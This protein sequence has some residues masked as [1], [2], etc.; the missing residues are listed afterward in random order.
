M[1]DDRIF[2]S[3][4]KINVAAT[5]SLIALKAELLAK[6]NAAVS[7]GR[8]ET[9][10][11]SSSKPKWQIKADE[12]EAKGELDR[13]KPKR[14][15]KT[16]DRHPKTQILEE[17]PI[18][19]E[20]LRKSR[21]ALERKTR[22]YEERYQKARQGCLSKDSSEEEDDDESGCLI[23]FVQ[24][25]HMHNFQETLE[26]DDWVEF[27]DSL[28]R[29][30][31]CRKKD[32]PHFQSLD[33]EAKKIVDE[34]ISQ[35]KKEIEQEDEE[36]CMIG[37]MLPPEEEAVEVKP[38][39]RYNELVQDE[40]RDHG[41]GFFNFSS[42]DDER[43]SQRDLL[44]TLREQTRKQR[45]SNEKV[46][47]RRKEL[48]RQRLLKIA[49]KKGIE[50]KESKSSSDEDEPSESLQARLLSYETE[51][52][53]REVNSLK[54]TLP[55]EWDVGKKDD[56]GRLVRE[57]CPDPDIV[58]QPLSSSV[59]RNKF[60]LSLE[61]TKSYTS[62][63]D[64]NYIQKRR[65]ER[66]EEFAPPSSYFFEQ[67]SRPRGFQSLQTSKKKPKTEEARQEDDDIEK[68]ISDKL[69]FFKRAN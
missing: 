54:E 19:E 31:Q 26:A 69:A 13:I 2:P 11:S 28:G 6:K 67:A 41:V 66:D 47:E 68:I 57:A 1:A 43:K 16:T 7:T 20:N 5:S 64:R 17:D 56:R 33:E 4:K 9:A 36:E 62:P 40:V 3:S 32:L 63:L 50:I 35:E 65:Q 29:T 23:N 46:K 30:R 22:Q 51:R 8:P 42:N 58:G 14:K 49:A 45:E 39:V 59:E 21:E 37:P 38:T 44:E 25:A 15:T 27:T 48:K 34:K 52:R 55:R 18:L 12:L 24:K 53:N 60:D 10:S 61:S